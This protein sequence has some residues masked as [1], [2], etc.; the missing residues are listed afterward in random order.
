[1]FANAIK[2]VLKI[3]KW[4]APE[5][6]VVVFI[7]CL[8]ISDMP[9]PLEFAILCAI[10]ASSGIIAIV[11]GC[12]GLYCVNPKFWD[13]VHELHNNTF[14]LRLLPDIKLILVCLNNVLTKTLIGEKEL[15][16][17]FKNEVERQDVLE[18]W[19][20]DP[21]HFCDP[22]IEPD[23]YL[24]IA[25]DA[26]FDDD[27]LGD[28]WCIQG[29]NIWNDPLPLPE[30]KRLGMMVAARNMYKIYDNGKWENCGYLK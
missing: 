2:P 12:Y 30:S 17:L 19:T 9:K 27:A 7:L 3:I 5:E 8:S 13:K 1:M 15:F 20:S 10:L 22:T 6:A 14:P 4:I 21:E 18:V 11:S 16:K 29:E 26:A 25:D 24:I 28:N 23:I